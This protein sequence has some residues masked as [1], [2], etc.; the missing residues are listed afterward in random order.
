MP[1]ETWVKIL[2]R[3]FK[4]PLLLILVTATVVAF[5][6]GEKLDALVI[7]FMISLSI[8]LGF[9][10]EF[11]AEKTVKDLLNKISFLATVIKNGVKM[12]IPV[13]DIRVGDEILLYPGAVVPA[14][15]KL[16]NISNLQINESVLSGEPAPIH[17]T[18]EN[19][20][21]FMGCIV[22]SGSGSGIVT[23]IGR[24][25]R[26]GQISTSVATA[27]PMTQFQK[28]LNDFGSLL[29]KVISIMALVILGLNVMLGRPLLEA[30]LFA[31]TVAIG[32]TPELLPI[33]V[34]ISLAHGAKRL[35]KKDVVVK[36]LV[37][38]E[39][40]GNMEVLCSD[41]TGTLTEGKLQLISHQNAV[42]TE[43]QT[44]LT[45]GLLCNSA[46]VH[47]RIIG[48]AIDAAIWE[49]AR[50]QKFTLPEN[51]IKILDQPFDYEHRGM[52]SV[53]EDEGVR[54]FIFKGAPD[55]IMEAIGK[56]QAEKIGASKKV[57]DWYAQGYRV[58][59]IAAKKVSTDEKYTYGDAKKLKF[60][61]WILFSDPP[62]H[63]ARAALDKFEQMGVKLK[64]I[65]GDNEVVTQKICRDID[66]PCEKVLTGP[67]LLKMTETDLINVV[68]SIDVFA[69]MTPDAKSRI[70]RALKSGGHT[71]GYI[72]DGINDAPALHEADAGISVDT[73]VDVAKDTA[74]IVLLK[75]SLMVIAEGIAEGRRTFANTLKYILMGTSS[76][77]GNM[78]SMAAASL[79]LPFLPM[80]PTQ[81]LLANALYDVSQMTIPTD[82]V[83]DSEI[84]TPKKWDIAKIKR[85]MLF[86]GPISSIY[87]FI[88]FGV[89][90]YFFQ[91]RGSLFQTGWFV[92]SLA[93]QILVIFVIRTK[94]V[95]FWKSRP[96]W[97]VAVSSLVAVAIAALLPYSKIAGVFGMTKLP[98]AFFGILVLMVGT[99]LGVV[100]LGKRRLAHSH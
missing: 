63:G 100:E 15:M 7:L 78:F 81:I 38:I 97:Q 36:Q 18:S 4:N 26:F 69:R 27:K 49:H 47:H 61:G 86:F 51:V 56:K 10:N 41:K 88:T 33:V 12:S 75:K 93:T 8:G 40:L 20:L 44:V 52:F 19:N 67:E 99:Y 30:V 87:D 59:G 3:Q 74:S 42:G 32:L 13:K 25:T 54:T 24:K 82:K 16:V 90:Y 53:V 2:L 22:T 77:F 57:A 79:L 9:A 35:S 72:G 91:A 76:N 17:K 60:V 37:A 84:L 85:D 31:L 50:H 28:G 65:T 62:K 89:M 64:I 48:D 80:T 55:K 73:A 23:A 45:M 21:A 46:V 39:D 94:I 70:I 14:D 58:I 68:W 1:E 96:S 92:E 5:V 95:P 11:G 6:F 43:D 34:T 66:V 71:V 29:V 98:I 83:D